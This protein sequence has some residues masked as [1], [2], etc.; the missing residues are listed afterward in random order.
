MNTLHTLASKGALLALVTTLLSGCTTG[1]SK[2]IVPLSIQPQSD[3]VILVMPTTAAEKRYAMSDAWRRGG[4]GIAVDAASGIYTY[5]FDD[6]DYTHL[7]QSLV[8]SLQQSKSFGAVHDVSNDTNIG[9]GTRLYIRFDESG[10]KPT[11]WGNFICLIRAQVWTEDAKGNLLAKKDMA[12]EEK[13]GITVRAAKNKAIV[14]FVQEVGA[15]LE[16]H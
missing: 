5:K 10:M 15:L 2:K 3:R 6:K 14:R 8:E 13:S 7:R 16:A 11:R 1:S 9:D 12:V 4:A